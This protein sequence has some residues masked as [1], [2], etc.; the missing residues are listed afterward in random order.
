MVGEKA[1]QAMEKVGNKISEIDQESI[2]MRA[3]LGEYK[4]MSPGHKANF[5]F[6]AFFPTLPINRCG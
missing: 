5:A 6:L 1:R 3:F 4:I 2:F